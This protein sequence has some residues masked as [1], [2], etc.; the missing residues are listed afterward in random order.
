MKRTLLMLTA[1]ALLAVYG[2]G[3]GGGSKTVTPTKTTQTQQ[4][5]VVK[6]R[7][8]GKR[9]Y[10]EGVDQNAQD[11]FRE[12][13]HAVNQIP[14]D[15]QT[16]VTKFS[17]AID[18]DNKFI[19]AYLNLGAVYERMGKNE[20][21]IETYKRIRSALSKNTGDADAY[22][23]RIYLG[24]GKLVEA[25]QL[26]EQIL[27]RNPNH[28]EA[29][30]NLA[31][32]YRLKG[33]VKTAQK[34]IKEVLLV[35]PQN[36]MALNHLGIIY[37]MKKEWA[38]AR[39]VLKDKVLGL[40]PN[41]GE[42]WT[43][44]G[45]VFVQLN[46]LPQAVTCF[47][48]ALRINTNNMAAR[49]NLGA[50]FLKYLHYPAAL[51]QYKVV[52]EKRPEHVEA[53]IGYGSS[54]WGTGKPKEAAKQYELA[55][56]KQPTH[57]ILLLRLGKMN[58]L[59]LNDIPQAVTYYKRWIAVANPAANHVIRQKVKLL[60]SGKKTTQLKKP[61][62]KK[63]TKPAPKKEAPKTKTAEKKK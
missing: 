48:A 10:L 32:Y 34:Y 42:A 59:T 62:P 55:L 44:L 41:N 57:K 1:L 14:P 60:A 45:L 26:F 15:Y 30:N 9:Q 36:V 52:V 18:G 28:I 51:E 63:K 33:D 38:L 29:K 40:E 39:Y 17:G 24:R 53:R 5:Q 6:K 4:K 27:Q 58:E 25:K 13:V 2:P 50:I 47:R 12:G 22:I 20:K 46:Q 54:L 11:L 7:R 61:T 19:E 23:G 21:A 49:L 31:I 37:Y 3:C 8:V 43:N 35:K 16:A 56:A